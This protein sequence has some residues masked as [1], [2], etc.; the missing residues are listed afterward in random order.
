MP[1]YQEQFPK[2]SLVRVKDQ[3]MLELF[4]KEWLYHNPLNSAQLIYAGKEGKVVGVGFYHG[5]DVLYTLE[6]MPGIWREQCLELPT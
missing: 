3:A 4:K 5:G 1:I 2:D 6:S